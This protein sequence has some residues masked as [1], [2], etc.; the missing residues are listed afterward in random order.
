MRLGRRNFLRLLGA[1]AASAPAVA[2]AAG[3]EALTTLAGHSAAPFAVGASIGTPTVSQSVEETSRAYVGMSN[4]LRMMG[5]LPEHV[6]HDV[7]E[8]AKYVG[9]LDPDIAAMRSFSLSAK[10]LWQQ[11]RNYEREVERYRYMGW[12]ETAQSTFTKLTGFRWQW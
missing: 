1:G 8:R 11:E 12:Y 2:K 6:E 3:M 4:Y 5:R 7:R 9:H 10:I